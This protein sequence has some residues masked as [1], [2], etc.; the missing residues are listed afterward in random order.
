MIATINREIL[1]FTR[2]TLKLVLGKGLEAVYVF[3]VTISPLGTY[4]KLLMLIST[5]PIVEKENL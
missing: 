2:P 1:K 5:K 3:A 4:F